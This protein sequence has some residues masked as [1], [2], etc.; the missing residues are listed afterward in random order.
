MLVDQWLLPL[1]LASAATYDNPRPWFVNRLNTCQV[2]KS[3]SDAGHSIYAFKGTQSFR[4]WMVDFLAL[5][6]P[7][8]HHNDA[9]AVHLG[10]WLDTIEAIK[11]IEVDLIADGRP[12][13]LLTGHSKGGAEAVLAHLELKRY[14]LIPLATRCF[15]PP[16]VGTVHLSA[17]LASDDI[18]WTQAINV[19]G[20]DVVTLVPDWPEWDHQG[21]MTQLQVPDSYGIAQKH[22]I[23]SILSAV[24]GS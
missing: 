5:D 20:K 4:E 15:E 21:A 1:C 8:L 18:A 3:K 12:S 6:V 23:A 24:K 10:F 19:H 2:Y 16:M 17:C 9:G 7:F 11:A 14:G 13:F 22:E